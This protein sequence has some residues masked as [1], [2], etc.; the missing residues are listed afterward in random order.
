VI[1]IRNRAYKLILPIVVGKK[2]SHKNLV[3]NI[4]NN[5]SHQVELFMFTWNALICSKPID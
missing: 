4:L 5:S 2:K 3:F 1:E